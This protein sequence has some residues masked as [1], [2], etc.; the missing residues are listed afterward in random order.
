MKY[1]EKL[2]K[3]FQ[4]QYTNSFGEHIT[5]KVADAELNNL[6]RLVETLFPVPTQVSN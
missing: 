5:L 3:R 6:A 1:S 2:L 4:K